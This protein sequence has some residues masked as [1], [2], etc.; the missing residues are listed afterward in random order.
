MAIVTEDEAVASANEALTAA[1]A[2]PD[3]FR[4]PVARRD[5]DEWVIWYEGRKQLVGNFLFAII[6]DRS[7]DV[8]LV[9]G[10]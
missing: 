5:Q 2:K 9:A 1:G 3:D 10:A 7:G 4:V 6:D 8:R